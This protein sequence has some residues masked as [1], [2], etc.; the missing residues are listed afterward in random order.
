MKSKVGL[1]EV[2]RNNLKHTLKPN[3]RKG[4]DLTTIEEKSSHQLNSSRTARDLDL[5][6][7][8]HPPSPKWKAVEVV[9]AEMPRYRLNLPEMLRVS[10]V[11][12]NAF[13]SSLSGNSRSNSFSSL[14]KLKL[15]SPK[16]D[17]DSPEKPLGRSVITTYY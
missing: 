4:S 9:E 3:P 15:I 6:E 8:D 17:A 14:K 13:L 1:V 11:S 12:D 7:S 10:D 2:R 16:V 5:P